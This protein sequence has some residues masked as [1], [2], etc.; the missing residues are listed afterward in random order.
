MKKKLTVVLDKVE[1]PGF[2]LWKWSENDYKKPIALTID[3]IKA[4]YYFIYKKPYQNGNLPDREIFLD[5]RIEFSFLDPPQELIKGL[6]NPSKPSA[7]A[8]AEYLYNLYKKTIDKLILY[9]RCEL[10][11]PSIMDA[12]YTG[13]NEI[14]RG[15]RSSIRNNVSWKYGSSDW[16]KFTLLTRKRASKINPIFFSRNLL[17]PQKWIRLIKYASSNPEIGKEIEELIRIKSQIAWGKKRI[18]VIEIAALVELIIRNNVQ[19]E[20]KNKGQSNKKSKIAADAGLSVL[21]NILLPL[22]LTKSEV[23]KYKSYIDKLDSLRKVRND[24]MHENIPEAKIDLNV[25]KNGV[26]AAIKITTLLAKK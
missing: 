17:T 14:F 18:P 4:E 13:F 23:K 21:L 15:N 25:V 1:A 3:E 8:A 16:R 11:L 10:K 26:D 2:V 7:D 9:G 22:I 19:S 20:L 6:N 12:H 5:G 24:V